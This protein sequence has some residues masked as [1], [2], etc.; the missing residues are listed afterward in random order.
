MRRRVLFSGLALLA[1]VA[2]AKTKADE[3]RD[4]FLQVSGAQFYRRELPAEINANG[5]KVVTATTSS[6]ARAGDVDQAASGDLDRSANAVAI[7]LADDVGYWIVPAKVPSASSPT[8]PTFA[9]QLAVA[10]DA[11]VGPH[12]LVFR[13]VDGDGRFGPPLLRPFAIAA[14]AT[15]SGHLVIEL[16][17][18]NQADLD[19][20][21]LLP[22]GVELFKRNRTEYQHPPGGA[23]PAPNAPIDGGV[24]DR[25]A[26]AQCVEGGAREE[27]AVWTEPPPKGH[28]AVRVDTFSLC[29]EPSAPWRLEAILDGVLV[30]AAQGMGTDADTR[31]AHDRGAGVLAFEL[32][33]P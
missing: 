20:H 10:A 33:V 26:N 15:P 16:T 4:A 8:Q 22:N 29:G 24:L 6:L 7:A 2:C 28:Y 1:V 3:G 5:P 31:F 13:A 25:D 30:G 32:D 21:V 23:P 18:E 17:W 14:P 9:A 19:L 12:S 27:D 11:P